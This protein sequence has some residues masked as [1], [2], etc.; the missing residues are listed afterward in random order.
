MCVC[1]C[2]YACVTCTNIPQVIE[3][4]GCL[5][6]VRL[7]HTVPPVL[8]FLMQSP[9]VNSKSMQSVD[10]VMCGAAPVP[11]SSV[12]VLQKKIDKEL[13]YQ[14]GEKRQLWRVIS[15]MTTLV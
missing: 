8:N 14:E 13:F 10:S 4:F 9:D 7:L 2:V 6:Q 12:E 1:T 5:P 3:C 15:S 11:Q